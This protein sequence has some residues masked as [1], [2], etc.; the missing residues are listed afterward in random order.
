MPNNYKCYR[1]NYIT[2]HKSSIYKHFLAKKKCKLS[3][4]GLKYNDD[5]V[6]KYSLCKKSDH[7]KFKNRISKYNISKSTA[8]FI[9]ELKYSYKNSLRTC[10]FCNK[11]FEKYF[12]LE[13]HLFECIEINDCND[14]KNN[15]TNIDNSIN[16]DNSITNNNNI[17]NN[18]NSITNNINNYHIHFDNKKIISFNDEWNTDHLNIDKKICLFLSTFKF[19]KTLECI[20]ENDSNKN[21]LMNNDNKTCIIYNG[22]DENQFYTLNSEDILKKSIMKLY[23]H[24]KDFEDEII[25]TNCKE[26][27]IPTTLINQSS[28]KLDEKINDYKKNDSVKESVNNLIS[29]IFNKYKDDVKD[30]YIEL[31]N[32]NEIRG[33]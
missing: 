14:N 26:Y 27:V 32:D 33:F 20:L 28:K 6:V 2:D 7:D 29:D 5:E 21:I 24:L 13:Y 25:Q 19:T 15:I 9:D 8:E 3:V 16:N 1:C 12:D 4:F 31:S 17:I 11:N 23:K 30:K 22:D 18:N 10:K